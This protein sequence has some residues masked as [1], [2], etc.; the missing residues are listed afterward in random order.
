M[1][2]LTITPGV[3]IPSRAV[4]FRTSRSSG[5]GGQNVNKLE[6]KVEASVQLDDI[7]GLN[8]DVRRRLR[9][10]LARAVDSDGSFRV[11]SQR[12]RS[13]WKNKEEALAR[14]IDRL[15]SAL[16]TQ[17]KRIATRP[18]GGSAERR[19]VRKRVRSQ[20]KRMRGRVRGDED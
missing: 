3:T 4:T 1:P 18:G 6:T 20:H 8:D 7:V 15:R 5:P 9:E 12:H 14:L 19:L 11:S 10:R 2:D 16:A 17:K 13:Q